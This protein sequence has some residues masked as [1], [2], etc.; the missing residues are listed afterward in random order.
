MIAVVGSV[1]RRPYRSGIRRGDAPALVCEA[2]YRLFS[3]KGYMDTSIEDIAAEAGVARPTV[4]SAVGP[5]PAILRTVVEQALAGDDAPVPIAE[6]PW[7]REAIEEPDPVRSIELYARN[8]CRISGRA[9]L[10]LRALESA[11][12]MD[13]AAAD[14]W[15]RFQHQRRV[16]LNQFAVALAQKTNALR[17]D[18][19]T[20]TDTMWT[21][22]PDAY[23]RLVHDAGWPVERFQA[24]LADL[25]Q[26][27][28]LE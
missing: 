24:W 13:A 8:M 12:S 2:A 21:L 5:K 14:V 16:G 25:L 7:W 11:A 23:L 22:A 17:Y 26:R 3:T 10:V 6:R 28:F 4:F 15:G 18:E 1:K 19:D 20:I 9:G 27:M